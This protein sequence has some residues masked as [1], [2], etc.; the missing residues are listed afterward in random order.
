MGGVGGPRLARE[1]TSY[2]L[3]EWMDGGGGVHELECVVVKRGRGY[4]VRQTLG[5]LTIPGEG[6]FLLSG[7]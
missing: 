3:W 7:E 6:F 5:K 1:Q 4:C 2:V